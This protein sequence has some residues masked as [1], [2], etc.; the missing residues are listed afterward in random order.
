MTEFI[1]A[2]KSPRRKT[3]LR[4]LIDP[5]IVINSDVDEREIPGENPDE[6]VVRLAKEKALKGGAGVLTNSLENAFVLGAD[7]IVVDGTEI[8]GKPQ[9]QMDAARILEQLRDKTHQVLSGIALYNLSTREIQTRLVCTE[10]VMREYT[11][12]EIRDYIASGDP[13]DKAG[14]YGIQNRDFNP[15]PDFFGCFANVM[16]LP[17]CHL[18]LLMKEMGIETDHRVADRCQDSIDYQCPI[19][20]DVLAGTKGHSTESN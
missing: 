12:D 19:Y 8:L 6:F 7:T 17:L 14:A 11:D 18:A 3:L 20:A 1:L 4:N 5:F 16:G 13:M 10:V 9:D 15:A 2:S